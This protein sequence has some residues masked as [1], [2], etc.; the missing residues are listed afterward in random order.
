MDVNRGRGREREVSAS[1]H[2]TEERTSGWS[3]EMEMTSAPVRY[4]SSSNSIDGRSPPVALVCFLL[5]V[6]VTAIFILVVLV[7][8]VV[9]L[10]C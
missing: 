2:A 6:N 1:V 9:V 4:T 3:K 10:V 7:L 8:I 5:V